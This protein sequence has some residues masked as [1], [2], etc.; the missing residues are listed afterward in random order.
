MPDNDN[1]DP[2]S[3][4]LRRGSLHLDAEIYQ[5]YFAGL[6]AVILLVRDDHLYVMPVRNMA[7]GGYLLK[8]RNNAGDRIINAMDFFREHGFNNF[9]SKKLDV[10]W[11]QEMAAL[12]VSD[13]LKIAN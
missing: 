3:V 10:K 2:M 7:G 6:D 11:D 8:L 13:F 12:K 5:R 1:T 4:T 9:E